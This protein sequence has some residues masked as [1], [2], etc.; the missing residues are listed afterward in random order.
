MI[1]QLAV[2]TWPAK[3]V[4]IVAVNAQTGERRAFHRTSGVSLVDAMIATTACFGWPPAIIDGHHYTYYR[5]ARRPRFIYYPVT[6]LELGRP[7]IKSQS[8]RTS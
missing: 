4:S 8:L 2:Q 7:K 5:F 3:P 1:A 6:T